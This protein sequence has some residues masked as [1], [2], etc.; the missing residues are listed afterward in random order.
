MTP[1]T[2]YALDKFAARSGTRRRRRARRRKGEKMNVGVLAAA[3]V[4]YVLV[5]GLLLGLW[6]FVAPTVPASCFIYWAWVRYG[7]RG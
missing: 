1:Q 2:G 3:I 6:W 5:V 4:A 7:K